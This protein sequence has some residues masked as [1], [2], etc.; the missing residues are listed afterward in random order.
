MYHLYNDLPKCRSH[1]STRSALRPIRPRSYIHKNSNVSY[2]WQIMIVFQPVSP[3]TYHNMLGSFL[4]DFFFILA[5]HVVCL[6]N[7]IISGFNASCINHYFVL[8]S[9]VVSKPKGRLVLFTLAAKVGPIKPYEWSQFR[10]VQFFDRYRSVFVANPK[11]NGLNGA[12][13]S[14]R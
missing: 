14:P 9:K 4:D 8:N 3:A 10:L 7:P 13:K 11:L 1:S 5:C 6:V 12:D 2:L